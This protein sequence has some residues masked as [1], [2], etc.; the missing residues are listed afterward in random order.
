[1]VCTF[2]EVIV[3]GE[4]KPAVH[5]LAGG[6]VKKEVQKGIDINLDQ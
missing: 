4:G 5:K 2:D 3:M 6:G 1:V